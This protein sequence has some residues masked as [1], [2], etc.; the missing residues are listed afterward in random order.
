MLLKLKATSK[1]TNNPLTL[2]FVESLTVFADLQ[3]TP[4]QSAYR[5]YKHKFSL[6]IGLHREITQSW[7]RS[8]AAF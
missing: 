4:L 8:S 5:I 1:I 2:V 3:R 6:T 7:L